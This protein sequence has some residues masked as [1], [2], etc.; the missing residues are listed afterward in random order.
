M[1]TWKE[2]K[3][4]LFEED[5]KVNVNISGESNPGTCLVADNCRVSE[6]L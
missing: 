6:K 4:Y 2:L 5:N 3:N 1:C